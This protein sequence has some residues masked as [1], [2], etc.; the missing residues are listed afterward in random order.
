MLRPGDRLAVSGAIAGAVVPLDLRTLYLKDL[1]LFGGTIVEPTV[2]GE[3]IG[4]IERGEITPLVG[5]IHPMSNIVASQQQFEAKK[6]I[7]KI[8]LV[9][10]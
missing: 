8:V 7:G 10:G 9:P 6:H 4:H 1:K 3:L 2:F 5:A